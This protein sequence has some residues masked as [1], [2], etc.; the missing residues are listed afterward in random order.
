MIGRLPETICSLAHTRRGQAQYGS[1]SD[2]GQRQWRIAPR[3]ALDQ[4]QPSSSET[5]LG[6]VAARSV[7]E[8][9]PIG[10]GE[11]W[12]HRA[13]ATLCVTAQTARQGA[14]TVKRSGSPTGWS[15]LG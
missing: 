1:P 15:R 14:A 2:H 12:L 8:P 13:N 6:W 4:P 5:L 3:P 7:A 10:L 9:A 11:P